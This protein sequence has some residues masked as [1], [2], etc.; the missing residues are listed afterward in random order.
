[1]KKNTSG[2]VIV[3]QLNA[4]ADGTAVTSG[5]TT[6]YVLGDGG[7][8]ASGSGTV[9]HEGQGCWSYV[10]TQAETNYDHIAFT[11]TNS[12]AITQ[13]VQVYTTFPQTGDGFARLGAPAGAS[14]AA[15]IAT[16]DGVV[17]TIVLDTAELQTDWTDGGRLDLI[18]DARASQ[19][20]AS[21]IEA[22]T[23]DIQSR[24]PAALV[25]GRIDSN[26]GAVSGDAAAADNLETMLDGT[27]GGTLSLG[28]LVVHN[29]SGTDAALHIENDGLAPAAY[30]LNPS[31]TGIGLSVETYR[32][33]AVQLL[34]DDSAAALKL[35]GGYGIQIIGNNAGIQVI[36]AFSSQPAVDINGRVD[37]DV[38]SSDPAV[39][40]TNAH[41]TGKGIEVSTTGTGFTIDLDGE[42][43][44]DTIAQIANAIWTAVTRTLSAATNITAPIADAVWDEALADHLTAGTTGA[45]LDTAV[46]N[47]AV[48]A[49]IAD[50]VAALTIE[51]GYTLQ[52]TL[53]LIGAAVAGKLSGAATVTNTIRSM[54]D[55][56]DRITA[57]VD[58]SGNRTAVTHNV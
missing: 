20:T 52:Q 24:I 39:S 2:Q 30:I 17:D 15:D 28:R 3:A 42:V 31:A 55:S 54:D 36:P 19:T 12:S 29:N 34:N 18:L 6:V 8:Q 43:D 16:V 46:D 23:Q 41:A 27:G 25:G 45:A 47:I 32:G 4:L 21:A 38:N 50:A 11:F 33:P 5:T 13:T 53:Q 37:I 58:G 1:M 14:I 26:V 22:D 44:T 48:P 57:T 40:I 35:S 9:T 7:T 10:P 49:D 56:A 51:T